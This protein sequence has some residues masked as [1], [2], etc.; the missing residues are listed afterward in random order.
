MAGIKDT[1]LV[2]SSY[3]DPTPE[4]IVDQA[5]AIAKHIGARLSALIP[6]LERSRVAAGY[7]RHSLL[8][9]VPALIEDALGTSA[10]HA[11]KLFARFEKAADYR[12]VRGEEIRQG[13]SLVASSQDVARHARVH[14]LTLLPIG[15]L[16]GLD[17]LYA[18]GVIFGSGRP[19]MA[20]PAAGETGPSDSKIDDVV[21]AWDGGAPAARALADAMPVLERAKRVRVVTFD[22]EK[23][24][25]EIPSQA[26]LDRHLNAHG[27]KATFDTLSTG[28]HSIGKALNEYVRSHG[29][30][31]LVMGAFGHSRVREFILGGATRSILHAPPVPVFLSH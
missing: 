27:I 4:Y 7:P 29:A 31:L 13:S 1:M 3:P 26:E 16:I 17:E 14:D 25:A 21:V 6:V 20:L 22:D 10:R 23:S 18:E 28:G 8:M 9:D 11:D 12:G 15:E 19:C 2:L 24:I 30:N 5:A